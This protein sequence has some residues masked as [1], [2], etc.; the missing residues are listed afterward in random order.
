VKLRHPERTIDADTLHYTTSTGVAEFFGP[1]RITQGTMLMWCERGSYDTRAEHGRFTR[2]G[3]IIDGSQELRGDSL[4]YDKRSGEGRAWGHVTV[5][6]TT[7]DLLVRGDFG[8]HLQHVDSSLITGSAELVMM[9]GEDSLFLHADTLFANNDSITGRRILARRHVRFFKRDMQG[10]CDTMTYT[11]K[12]SVITLVGAPFIWSGKDQISGRTISIALRDGHAHLLHVLR[13]ALLANTVDTTET[14]FSKAYFDQVTGTNI[15]GWFA[16]D[17]LVRIETDGNSRTVYFAKE[18][19]KDSVERVTGM[20]RAD[21]SRIVVG[22]DSGKVSTVSFLTKPDAV[23][24]PLGKA[25]VEEMRMKG[26]V[27]NA[28]ARPK[29]RNGIFAPAE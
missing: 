22:L 5:I 12:D 26:F 29:D 9:M 10:V 18:M 21:C 11:E 16:N 23:M 25:P 13:D 7:N 6:D 3:R 19:G 8:R 24:Y 20:N 28:A 14:D 17:Q 4:H 1:T 2:N 15:T 27:W